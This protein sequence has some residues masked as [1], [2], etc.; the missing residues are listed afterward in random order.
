MANLRPDTRRTIV[1]ESDVTA[2]NAADA[3]DLSLH[4]E[5]GRADRLV[6]LVTL[7]IQFVF[8]DG[9]STA[10]ATRGQR[11]TW[12]DAQKDD[13]MRR[14]REV[15]YNTWNDRFRIRS[16]AGS[17]PLDVGVQLDIRAWRTRSISE[18]WEVSVER[19]DHFHRSRVLWG[20]NGLPLFGEAEL[21]SVDND[22]RPDGLVQRVSAHEFGHML[23]LPDEYN[24]VDLDPTFRQRPHWWTLDRQ[25]IMNAGEN[26]RGRHYAVFADWLTRNYADWL[27][28]DDRAADVTFEVHDGSN[29]RWTLANAGLHPG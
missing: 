23:G 27:S 26:P 18:H 15:C 11:L 10:P 4:P 19:T 28:P 17:P 5:L 25:S 22:Y 13:Y 16:A 8:T 3:F 24:D 20:R 1:S 9:A 21:S 2:L 6:L 7:G 14:F 12:T 29:T